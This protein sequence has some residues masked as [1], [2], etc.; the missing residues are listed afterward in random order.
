MA[1][2]ASA[3]LKKAATRLV[4]G[5]FPAIIRAQHGAGPICIRWAEAQAALAS[6]G[7]GHCVHLDAS[8][9]GIELWSSARHPRRRGAPSSRGTEPRRPGDGRF[10]RRRRRHQQRGSNGADGRRRRGITA[11]I[12]AAWWTAAISRERTRERR[13]GG[14]TGGGGTDERGDGDGFPELVPAARRL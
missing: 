12:R 13:G 11:V 5:A 2:A 6:F 3:G 7:R 14:T 1:A 10:R 4:G 8:P 9:D